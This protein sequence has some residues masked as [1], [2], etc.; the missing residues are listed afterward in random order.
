MK[1]RLL[2][3]FC[4]AGGASVG[5]ARAGFDVEGVD[6]KPQPHYPFKFY[7]ADALE[8]PLEGYDA[9]H[10]SPPCQRYSWLTERR[11]RFNHPDLIA[12][13]RAR[14]QFRYELY[15]SPYVIENVLGAKNHLVNPIRLCGTQ[16]G[17]AVYR[18]RYFECHP[19][20]YFLMPPCNHHKNPVL[21]SGTTRRKSGRIENSVKEKREGMQIDWM[22]GVDLD[23]AI[24]PAYT[25]YIGKYLIKAIERGQA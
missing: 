20:L 6:I 25:E 19:E 22:T 8:F 17:L 9:Y 24:P 18:H 16:F 3:L 21:V 10:A 1:P 7:Q 11:F 23:Q 5:Y 2:D 12:H 13:I 15:E 14:L 4:G